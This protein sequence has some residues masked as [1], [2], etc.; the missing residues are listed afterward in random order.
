V[1]ARIRGIAPRNN[2]NPKVLSQIMLMLSHDLSQTTPD[3][4]ADYRAAEAARGNEPDTTQAGV[5]DC[6]CAEG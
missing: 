2:H 6:R 4:I 3:T 1:I 5:L